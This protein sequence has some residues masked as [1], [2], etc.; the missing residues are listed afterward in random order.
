MSLLESLTKVLRKQNSHSARERKFYVRHWSITWGLE[1]G[2]LKGEFPMRVTFSTKRLKAPATI[3][4]RQVIIEERMFPKLLPYQ[5][6]SAVFKN[7]K[8]TYPSNSRVSQIHHVHPWSQTLW[9]RG[10]PFLPLLY[11]SEPTQP[12]WLRLGLYLPWWKHF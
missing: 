8:P 11:S 5:G 6:Q 1:Y 7:L 12:S 2:S 4:K 3:R 9:S 10:N